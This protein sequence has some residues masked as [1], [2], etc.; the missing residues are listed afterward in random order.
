[1]LVE[2]T[3]GTLTLVGPL[4]QLWSVH[5]IR[6]WNALGVVDGDIQT[7]LEVLK[8]LRLVFRVYHAWSPPNSNTDKA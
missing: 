2:P 3:T 7:F 8:Y 1:M 5:S 4:C 6:Y